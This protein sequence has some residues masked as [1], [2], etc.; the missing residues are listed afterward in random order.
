MNNIPKPQNFN[1][2]CG[3]IDKA[4]ERNAHTEAVYIAA[5]YYNMFT[6]CKLLQKL[7]EMHLLRGHMTEGMIR[8]RAEIKSDIYDVA[9]TEDKTE[10][11]I[12]VSK[13]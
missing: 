2:L 3:M 8:V 10:A 6:H 9:C 13:I 4:T 12:L 7:D 5:L 1:Q 11:R